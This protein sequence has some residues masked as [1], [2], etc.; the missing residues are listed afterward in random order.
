MGDLPKDSPQDDSTEVIKKLR[1]DLNQAN[2]KI[3]VQKLKIKESEEAK[4]KARKIILKY[5]RILA[6]KNPKAVETQ[7]RHE[8]R[9]EEFRQEIAQ[10]EDHYN[11]MI[12]D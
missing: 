5:S 3:E 4:L 7:R 10:L 2:E 6:S 8:R 12:Q 1:L 9:I 11:T